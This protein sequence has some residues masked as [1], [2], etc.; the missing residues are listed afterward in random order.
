MWLNLLIACV[1][2]GLTYGL[3]LYLDDGAPPPSAVI[4]QQPGNSITMLE[5]GEQT[6]EFTFT[7]LAG[8]TQDIKDFKGKIIL[9]N[10]WATWCPPCIAEMPSLLN[11][12][13][14]HESDVVLIALSSDLDAESIKN[15]LRRIEAAESAPNILIGLDEQSRVTQDIFKVFKLPETIVIDRDGMQHAKLIGANWEPEALEKI[16][17]ELK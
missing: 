14:T 15:F 17:G 13:K 7:T 10:F 1:I 5:T 9:L 12:A 11:I 3:T 4:V 2:G 8:K 6:P 16:I